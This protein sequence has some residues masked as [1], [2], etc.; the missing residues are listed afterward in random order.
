M[1][2]DLKKYLALATDFDGTLAAD[3]FVDAATIA[4]LVALRQ[5]GRKVILITGR[6]LA[7]LLNVF[8]EIQ[9]CDR[10][11]A[12]NG[13]LLYNPQTQGVQQL[14]ESPSEAFIAALKARGVEPLDIGQGIVATWQ[15]HGETVVQV[16]E[17]MNLNWQVIL[18]KRAVM[19]LPQGI[20]K[21]SGLKAACN[22]LN[23]PLEATIG[24]G[25]AENDKHLLSTS[26]Y[27][28][29]V[30]NAIASLQEMADWVTPSARGQGVQELIQ[31]WLNLQS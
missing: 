6:H 13:A 8:P 20:D 1:T 22:D 26:G 7:D 30:A 23:L 15:P 16:I 28:V 24:I 4:G 29:A 10:V 17:E 21:A 9:Q 25:D 5:S 3:G 31:S 18:N 2:N 14:G 27:G 19:A 11:V 12:E